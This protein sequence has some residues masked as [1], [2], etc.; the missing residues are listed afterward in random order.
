MEIVYADQMKIDQPDNEVAVSISDG[1][2]T[3]RH[4]LALL[5][6]WEDHPTGWENMPASAEELRLA[7]LIRTGKSSTGM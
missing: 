3:P 7:R 6:F 4:Y 2:M 5:E 1:R